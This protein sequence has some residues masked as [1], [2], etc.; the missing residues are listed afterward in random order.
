MFKGQFEVL[1][2]VVEDPLQH[3]VQFSLLE[4]KFL[5][6]FAGSWCVEPLGPRKCKVTYKSEVQPNHAPPRAFG[7]RP[8]KILVRQ[9]RSILCDLARAVALGNR[10]QRAASGTMSKL[11]EGC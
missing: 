5:K 6:S 10:A 2:D 11:S 8:G 7:F 9:T 1:F 3:T 4:S